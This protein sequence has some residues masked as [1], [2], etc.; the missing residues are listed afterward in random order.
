[1]NCTRIRLP[2]STS[3]L[4]QRI[5]HLKN[6]SGPTKVNDALQLFDEMLQRQPPP[7][8]FQFTQLISLIVKEKQY[9]TALILLK[10]MKLMGIPANI[11]TINISI[12]CHCRL[13]QVAYGFALLATILKQGHPPSLATYT[14][15]IHGLVLAD[16]VFE[17][18]ELFKKLL[19]EKVCE[20][21][22]VMYGSVINGLCKVGHTSKALELHRFMESGSVK[23]IM[24]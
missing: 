10:Q 5:L 2:A 14:T 19:R 4:N 12:N 17:A 9:S 15:L 6:G 21:D 13:N 24:H 3:H 18:V 11:Y 1:M 22:Q 20:P 16:R 7:P 8:I 23:L